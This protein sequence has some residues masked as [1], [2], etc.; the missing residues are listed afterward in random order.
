MQIKNNKKVVIL[1]ILNPKGWEPIK[2]YLGT[3]ALFILLLLTFTPCL[4][5]TSY[6]EIPED[7]DA[8]KYQEL[9]R[10]YYYRETASNLFT[11]MAEHAKAISLRSQILDYTSSHQ[12]DENDVN[13]EIYWQE[14]ISKSYKSPN[15][16]KTRIANAYFTEDFVKSKFKQNLSL[17]NYFSKTV[18]PKI[19]DDL[20]FRKKVL[21]T[22]REKKIGFTKHEI[23]ERYY[24]AIENFGGDAAFETFLRNNNFTVKE[25][26][27]FIESDLLKDKLTQ[28]AIT[29]RIASDPELTKIAGM[30]N[31]DEYFYQEKISLPEYYFRMAY[32]S[33][34]KEYA[35]S[36]M[37]EAY[38]I[39]KNQKQI[40][41]SIYIDSD[42]EIYDLAEPYIEGSK[43]YS[44]R[45]QKTLASQINS[46]LMI[47]ENISPILS[48]E[49]GYYVLDLYKVQRPET[50][51]SYQKFLN[52]RKDLIEKEIKSNYSE[53]F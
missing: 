27:F 19:N 34:D 42:I 1:V 31:K 45:V 44:E 30:Q 46:N 14:Y 26:L 18:I 20:A 9:I 7:I 13:S 17:N 23:K 8:N 35:A 24:Q 52:K 29:K 11:S 50:N 53:I 25:F 32:I 10:K 47:L 49:S 41:S 36:K 6:S 39:F 38:G 12:L 48:N 33:K 22:A 51:I 2:R 3:T 16:F 21:N 15:E 37:K 4:A 43:L 40:S 5:E 28:M